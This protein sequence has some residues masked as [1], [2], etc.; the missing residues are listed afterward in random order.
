MQYYWYNF[1]LF[2][3]VYLW[4]NSIKFW[5]FQNCCIYFWWYCLVWCP[6]CYRSVA[7]CW[8]KLCRT[9]E[10][11]RYGATL[12]MAR[13]WRKRWQMIRCKNLSKRKT[14]FITHWVG[15]ACKKISSPEYKLSQWRMFEKT[16]CLITADRSDKM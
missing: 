6:E 4:H 15:A 11:P 1:H 12:F 3:S 16:R 9:T 2:P 7:T 10:N 8:W 14:F 5:W 13:Q